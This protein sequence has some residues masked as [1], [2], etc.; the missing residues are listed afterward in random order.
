MAKIDLTKERDTIFRRS[1]AAIQHAI[2][3]DLIIADIP[4]VQ[5]ADSEFDTF[6]LKP[7]WATAL[8]KARAYF[9]KIEDYEMCQICV[10]L[11]KKIKKLKK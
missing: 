1:V 5:V 8:E 6:V 10:V 3:N 11:T 7:D 4:K 2:D 9:E